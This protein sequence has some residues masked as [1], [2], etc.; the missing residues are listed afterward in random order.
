MERYLMRNRLSEILDGIGIRVLLYAVAA[1][2]FVWLWGL[3]WPTF[4]AGAAFGTL[5]CMVR[6]EWRKRTIHRREKA[7]RS[8]LGA[9]LMLEDMLM[10][11]AKEAHLRAAL[12]LA[13]KWPITLQSVKEEGVL[14]TQGTE[15][16]LLRC[17]RM[18][19]DGELSVGDLL[20]AQRA[21][22]TLAADRA[23]LCPLGKAS[24]KVLVRAEAAL[25]PLRIIPRST[26]LALA[27]QVSPATDEQLIALGQR[28][29]R[30]AGQGSLGRMM[31]RPEK[32]KRYH[33]Y[34]QGML[35]LY[36]L[37]NVWLYALA[38]MTCLTMAV[39][40]RW[41]NQSRELL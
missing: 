4:L 10:A 35:L 17:V 3:N 9:E 26:L 34:G 6:R 22:R 27:G 7:L 8:R 14:C 23:V 37:T 33:F 18:P 28:K 1:G 39:M 2:W 15:K 16:L 21:A 25:V 41:G 40:S 13:E 12:L 29:R 38:G 30:M 20:A 31:F 24:P 32:A 5:L 19:E 36:V 11:D